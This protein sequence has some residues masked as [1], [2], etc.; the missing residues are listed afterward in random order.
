MDIPY[1]SVA[2]KYG[3][4]LR[5]ISKFIC[6]HVSHVNPRKYVLY[7]DLLF[8]SL[9]NSFRFEME[10]NLQFNVVLQARCIKTLNLKKWMQ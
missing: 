3:K 9:M 4:T 5:L 6:I 8:A 10:R 7:D 1:V 2:K